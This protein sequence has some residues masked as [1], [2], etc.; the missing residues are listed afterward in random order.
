[1]EKHRRSRERR[2]TLA[3]KACKIWYA[4]AYTSGARDGVWTVQ[5][6]VHICKYM[7]FNPVNQLLNLTLSAMDTLRR[8]LLK[9][10][11]YALFT[12]WA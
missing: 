4:Y 6:S 1:M 3:C 12:L 10:C 9:Y 5:M 7:H 11:L 8:V 2:N